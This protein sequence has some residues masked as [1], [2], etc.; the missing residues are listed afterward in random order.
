MLQITDFRACLCLCFE[1]RRSHCVHLPAPGRLG[2][3]YGHGVTIT[4]NAISGA[5]NNLGS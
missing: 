3:H 2:L 4:L 1:A 5:C